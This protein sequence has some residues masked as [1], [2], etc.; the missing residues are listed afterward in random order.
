MTQGLKKTLKEM[1]KT[2][3]SSVS[4][5]KAK[6]KAIRNPRE[7]KLDKKDLPKHDKNNKEV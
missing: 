5:K 2:Y 6:A 4:K 7:Q 3:Y 1:V